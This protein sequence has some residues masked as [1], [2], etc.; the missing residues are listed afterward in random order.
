MITY[1]EKI[2]PIHGKCLFLDNGTVEVGV[3][4][5]FGIRICHFSFVGE[6]NVFFEQPNEMTD[7]TTPEGWRLRGGHRLWIAPES[8]DLY[9]PDNDPVRIERVE[10]GVRITQREDPV[11]HVVKEC[12]LT[13]AGERVHITHR[14][15]NTGE[16]RT[17]ALW[18]VSVLAPGGVERIP[19]AVRQGGCDPLHR[20][21]I[22]DH[23]TLGDERA[24]YRKDEVVLTHK[25]IDARYKLGVGH[26]LGDVRYVLPWA[27]FIKHYERKKDL[28][29]PDGDVSFETFLC[30]HMTELESLSPLYTLQPQESASHDEVWT[31]CRP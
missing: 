17:C 2:H 29:Y 31:L 6:R 28:C 20:F 14:I 26:P 3:P 19:L 5:S 11:L 4:L 15:Q 12:T 13:L 27:T 23:T 18:A 16:T 1:T 25:P 8:F 21:V 24:E 30:R 9:A 22:W 7:L 10:N